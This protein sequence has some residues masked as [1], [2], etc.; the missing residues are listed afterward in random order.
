M[1][2]EK[3]Y[4]LEMKVQIEDR[5]PV[6]GLKNEF[7]DRICKVTPYIQPE[8]KNGM[9]IISIILKN[10]SDFSSVRSFI[11]KSYTSDTMEYIWG[12]ENLKGEDLIFDCWVKSP[13]FDL[14]RKCLLRGY[15]LSEHNPAEHFLLF[16]Q[17]K[18]F[19]LTEILRKVFGKLENKIEKLENKIDWIIHESM[20]PSYYSM[21]TLFQNYKYA[22]ALENNFFENYDDRLLVPLIKE[23]H[24][25]TGRKYD[26]KT[27]VDELKTIQER[28]F[29]YLI[30]KVEK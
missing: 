5:N 21:L 9:D 13:S 26:T 18:N 2:V 6:I 14:I 10:K 1:V 22:M 29:N 19:L 30:S 16:H 3:D 11:E 12:S 17:N 24:I 15:E 23:M 20:P 27:M 8:S 4:W 28:V 7:G 25:V